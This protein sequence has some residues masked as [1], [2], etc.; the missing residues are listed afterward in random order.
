M[1]HA[2][3]GPVSATVGVKIITLGLFCGL[4]KGEGLIPRTR[5]EN[6][7]KKKKLKKKPMHA[8]GKIEF[9][10]KIT[11]ITPFLLTP[12]VEDLFRAAAATLHQLKKRSQA[13]GSANFNPKRICMAH[14]PPNPQSRNRGDSVPALLVAPLYIFSP[15]HCRLAL[16]WLPPLS[17]FFPTQAWKATPQRAA[18]LL[19]FLLPPQSSPVCYRPTIGIGIAV[20]S[21]PKRIV[22]NCA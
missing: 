1:L 3:Y 6:L 21:A 7:A 15:T 20:F 17:Y 19:V 18:T 9:A 14:T 11:K 2:S 16:L 13:C 4:D 5:C 22:T 10:K 8:L 12:P